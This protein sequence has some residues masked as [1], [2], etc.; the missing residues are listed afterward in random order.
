[1][2]FE[3]LQVLRRMVFVNNRNLI[4]S[5]AVVIPPAASGTQPTCQ[6]AAAGSSKA[7]GSRKGGKQRGAAA[8][9]RSV[10]TAAAPAQQ[11]AP[12]AAPAA[13][14]GAAEPAIDHG[15]LP[16][17]YH[18]AIVAGLSLASAVL[19]PKCLPKYFTCASVCTT[20]IQVQMRTIWHTAPWLCHSIIPC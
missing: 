4:Q 11:P 9:R 17:E 12:N 19:N 7:G 18:Q 13:N 2:L 5:E 10:T 14:G 3:Y 20:G 15:Q 8:P 16:C 6:P 1:M